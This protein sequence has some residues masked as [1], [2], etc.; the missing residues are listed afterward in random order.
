MFREDSKINFA[1]ENIIP[2]A[3]TFHFKTNSQLCVNYLLKITS[4][5]KRRPVGLFI[6]T[7]FTGKFFYLKLVL[8]FCSFMVYLCLGKLYHF[9]IRPGIDPN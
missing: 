4:K 5:I 6:Q 8:I 7:A 2:S 3:C 9:L 1:E